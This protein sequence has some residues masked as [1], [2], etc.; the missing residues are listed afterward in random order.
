[1]DDQF[2]HAIT[3]LSHLHFVATR[4]T[5]LRVRQMGEEARRVVVSG[6][7]GLDNLNTLKFPSRRELETRLSLPLADPPL[8]VT[9]HPATLEWDRTSDHIREVLSAL[10]VLDR[11]VVFTAPNTDPGSSIIRD[12][13]KSFVARHPSCRLVEN[14]GTAGYFALMQHSAAMLGNSSSGIIEAA[15]FRLPVVNIGSRQEGRTHG[16][17]VLDCPATCAAILRTTRQALSPAF[18]TSLRRLRNP[19][20][21]GQAS[22]RILAK[23]EATD[24]DTLLDKSFSGMGRNP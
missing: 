21:D 24:L 6:A 19:Y 14:L 7:L 16:A 22:A 17:N 20:G 3:K 2:R 13:I 8:L 18:H 5:G 12:S 1:M 11:P 23:L 10:N 4:E 9:F 15:S